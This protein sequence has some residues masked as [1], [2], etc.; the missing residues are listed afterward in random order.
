MQETIQTNF[1]D[2]LY[3]F[4]VS[5]TPPWILLLLDLRIEYS[6]FLTWSFSS[7][8]KSVFLLNLLVTQFSRAPSIYNEKIFLNPWLN[9]SL[10]ET[11]RD[12]VW[13]MRGHRYH[14]SVSL[15]SCTGQGRPSPP[16]VVSRRCGRRQCWPHPPWRLRPLLSPSQEVQGDSACQVPYQILISDVMNAHLSG[17]DF[18]VVVSVEGFE[19]FEIFS[20]LKIC[21][22]IS[23][24]CWRD[25]DTGLCEKINWTLLFKIKTYLNINERVKCAVSIEQTSIT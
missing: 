12:S 13:T 18:F 24:V 9:S 21:R 1:V 22:G 16:S 23:Q 19:E 7:T 17:K 10:L 8:M 4:L 3:L 11:L 15:L 25:S 20:E 14:S 2:D 6:F 5:P